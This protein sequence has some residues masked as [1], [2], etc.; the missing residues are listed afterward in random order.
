MSKENL[1]KVA[2]TILEKGISQYLVHAKGND[3]MMND[4]LL[5]ISVSGN[6]LAVKRELWRSWTG[7][8]FINGEEYHGPVFTI[9]SDS[10]FS[11]ERTCKCNECSTNVPSHLRSN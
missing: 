5:E 7:R 1:S 9:D 2:S 11:G 4:S 10:A 6:I 8:R 3:T